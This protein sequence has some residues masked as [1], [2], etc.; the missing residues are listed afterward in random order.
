MSTDRVLIGVLL[1][2]VAVWG[3]AQALPAAAWLAVVS[4]LLGG[5]ITACFSWYF[6][7]R[8]SRELK[9]EAGELRHYIDVL[10]SFLES[11]ELDSRVRVG[12]DPRTG[13]IINVEVQRSAASSPR[14]ASGAEGTP[15]HPDPLQSREEGS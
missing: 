4:V 11:L 15:T 7:Q 13:R 10:A 8:A 12:R 6:Y 9:D 2:C 3:T 1:G 5:A 14:G